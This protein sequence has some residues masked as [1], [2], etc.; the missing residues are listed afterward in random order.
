[1]P[2]ED[3]QILKRAD[4]YH[5][6]SVSRRNNVV[7]KDCSAWTPTVHSLLRHLEREQFPAPRVVGNGFDEDGRE[8]ITYIEGVVVERGSWS[9]ENA[10]E[11]GKLLRK[12]HVATGT[13]VPSGDAK[14]FPWYGRDL[15]RRDKVI[16]H[17]D[18]GPWNI[19]TRNGKPVALID[20]D[21]AGPVDP[22]IELAHACWLN[23][24]LHD[25]IVGDIEG[26]PPVTERA[27]HLRAIVDGYGL[28]SEIR[29]N[30][31]Q[32]IINVAI[33][34]TAAEANEADI[35]PDTGPSELAREV[36]WAI[37]WRARAA[38]WMTRNRSELERALR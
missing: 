14:W 17:C 22:V 34:E 32:D 36:P 25:D 13:Y 30:F 38:A 19:V 33:C 10:Y 23:A 15:G 3:E 7:H 29:A 27:K 9:P 26:L 8:T 21:F 6:K 28:E 31:V 5:P 18:L 35:K 24:K 12:L 1:M 20:W 4:R 2:S 37:A 16:G 11:I